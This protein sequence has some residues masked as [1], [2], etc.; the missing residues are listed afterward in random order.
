MKHQRT[1]LV[2]HSLV[3]S[4]GNLLTMQTANRLVGAFL[5][6]T[7]VL[8]LSGCRIK[9]IESFQSAT[10]PVKS[11]EK[12]QGDKYSNGGIADATGGV[13]TETSYNAGAKT[14]AAAKLNSEYDAPT[15]G[16]GQIPGE[17][18]GIGIGNGP[19]MQPG[20]SETAPTTG[21]VRG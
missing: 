11:Q 5:L 2:W 1:R 19:V 17:N 7:L 16:T 4:K 9:G 3:W 21:V 6:A 18:P 14:G 10:E 20:A 13:K 12:Y 8:M 15:K